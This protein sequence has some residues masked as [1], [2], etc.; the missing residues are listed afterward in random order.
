ML[1]LG[2]PRRALLLQLLLQQRLLLR[3]QPHCALM[4]PS[5]CRCSGQMPSG[6]PAS[7]G[8]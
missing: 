7:L 8:L 3:E 4:A 5:S 2:L 6:S 1:L